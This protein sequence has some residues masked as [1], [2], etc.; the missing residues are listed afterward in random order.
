MQDTAI[1]THLSDSFDQGWEAALE[2]GRTLTIKT[3]AFPKEA[4]SKDIDLGSKGGD[5]PLTLLT[6]PPEVR[7]L[8]YSYAYRL[9]IHIAS[10]DGK[11]RGYECSSYL[12]DSHAYISYANH[13]TGANRLLQN[14]IQAFDNRHRFCCSDPD[15]KFSPNLSYVN[16]QLRAESQ[17]ALYSAPDFIFDRADELDRFVANRTPA[18]LG[19]IRHVKFFICP[20]IGKGVESLAKLHGLRSMH[21]EGEEVPKVD[22]YLARGSRVNWKE[23]REVS[24]LKVE[25]PRRGK[26]KHQRTWT[27]DAFGIAQDVEIAMLK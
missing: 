15:T 17:F 25:V 18:Q 19:A 12:L 1:P 26:M 22:G 8:I 11:V 7:N 6:L 13:C 23:L 10:V 3:T 27:E 4:T 21:I 5:R 24:V 14:H 9:D 16:R 20:G 2:F